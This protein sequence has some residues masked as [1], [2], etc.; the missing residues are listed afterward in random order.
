MKITEIFNR[1]LR[2]KG[3]D[4]L[5]D[6]QSVASSDNDIVDIDKDEQFVT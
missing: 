6:T 3:S 1:E 5:I 4:K 2:S